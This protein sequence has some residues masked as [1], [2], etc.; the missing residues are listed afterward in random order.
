MPAKVREPVSAV[1]K[2]E[3]EGEEEDEDDHTPDG[4]PTDEGTD[5]DED[6]V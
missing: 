4:N 2:P 6:A 3:P 1:E 5:I